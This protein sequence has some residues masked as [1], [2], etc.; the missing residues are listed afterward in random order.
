M[1]Y[2]LIELFGGG[3]ADWRNIASTEYNWSDIF[4]TAKK[5]KKHII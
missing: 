5:L 3:S 4:E 1:E 2:I